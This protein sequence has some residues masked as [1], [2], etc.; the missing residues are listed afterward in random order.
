MQVEIMDTFGKDSL[1]DTPCIGI[2]STAIGD[3]VCI[4]CGRSFEEVNNWNTLSDN[5]KSVIN[6]RLLKERLQK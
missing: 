6:Q 2:C 1:I 3:A 5:E 4:G